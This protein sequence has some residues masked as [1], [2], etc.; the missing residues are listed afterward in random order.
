MTLVLPVL[1]AVFGLL[2][3]Y[4]RVGWL[5]QICQLVGIDYRFYPYGLKAFCWRISSLTCSWRRA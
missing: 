3:V 2:T 4:G 1:V 5:A